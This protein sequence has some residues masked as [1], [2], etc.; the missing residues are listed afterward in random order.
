MKRFFSTTIFLLLLFTGVKTE[1]R[2]GQTGDDDGDDVY[3]VVL[4]DV[5]VALNDAV[6]YVSQKYREVNLDAVLGLRMAEGQLSV[7]LE[8]METAETVPHIQEMTLERI[9]G[10]QEKMSF[11][12][13]IT[14]PQLTKSDPEQLA[15]K[16]AYKSY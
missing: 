6:N 3:E 7:L 11:L 12:C 10:L 5:L 1:S 9:R 2:G 16:F 13:D 4:N 15:C 8:R 14:Q